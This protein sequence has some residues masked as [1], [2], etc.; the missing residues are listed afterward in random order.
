MGSCL[1]G[2]QDQ[3][4]GLSAAAARYIWNGLAPSSRAQQEGTVRRYAAYAARQGWPRPYFPIRADQMINWVAAEATRLAERGPLARGALDSSVSVL[5]SWHTDLGLDPSGCR[6][7]LLRRTIRGALRTCGVRAAESTMPITLPILRRVLDVIK[8]RPR[9]FGG[10]TAACALRTVFTLA[11]ACFLRLGECTWD[12][13]MPDLHL[14]WDAVDFGG[15]SRPATLLLKM[16]KTDYDHQGVSVV[17][18]E[19]GSEVCPIAHLREWQSISRPRSPRDALFYLPGGNFPK[20]VVVAALRRAL[21]QAG[22]PAKDFSGHS[23]RRGAATWA[24]SIGVPDEQIQL[25]GRWASTAHRRY[26]DRP[27]ASIAELS[28][29]CLDPTAPSSLPA[30]GLPEGNRIWS[31][32]R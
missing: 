30:S 17:I 31:P 18:P 32:S 20:K 26:V 10:R 2:D 6:G 12:V 24:S 3:G 1:Y 5:A 11:F 28:R 29:R 22:L 13:F 25:L 16:S 4:T 27:A 9:D 15:A 8:A 21:L 23:F 7:P 19:S 14:T